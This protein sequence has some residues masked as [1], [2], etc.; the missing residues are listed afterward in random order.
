M[1]ASVARLQTPSEHEPSLSAGSHLTRADTAH[2]LGDVAQPQPGDSVAVIGAGISGLV[3]AHVLSRSYAVTV[4]EAADYAGGHTNTIEV[5]EQ[6]R[7]FGVD[8]GFIVYNETNY[9]A[10]TRLLAEL[11]VAT[12]HTSMSF[13]FHCERSGLEW[14]GS[15]LNTLMAR[16]RNALSPRFY[17]MLLDVFRFHEL[18]REGAI[19]TTGRQTV[20]EFIS[21]HGFSESFYE[22]Y[23]LPIG[24]SL[25][26][27]PAER[28]GAFP[29]KFVADFLRNHGMLQFRNRPRWRVI[30]GG[31]RRYVEALLSRLEAK[32]HLNAPID[33]V[34]RTGEGV[35][36]WAHGQPLEFDHAVVACHS[37]QALQMLADASE[38]ERQVLGPLKF[39]KNIAAL[40]TDT[41][42]LP[43]RQRAWGAWNYKLQPDESR[44]VPVTYN[45]NILQSLQAEQTYCVTLNGGD[46][47]D[48]SRLIREIVYHHPEY[49]V[50]AEPARARHHDVIGHR[51]TSYCGAYWG[52]GFHEAGVQSALRVASLFRCSL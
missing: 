21:D 49:S 27:S 7:T 10:F 36:V 22:L 29:I 4:F 41:R 45:M 26:S 40:H 44:P 15:D 33:R 34:E 2:P 11:G 48:R 16:R 42:M 28:F 20:R 25:W 5:H 37:D 46:A 50:E 32:V 12:K 13:G 23:L 47:I 35:R 14:N 9:P 1:Q 39:Q 19:D 43:T 24:A 17:A 38:T 52:N 18:D 6:G 3:A 51:R 30:E 8:T 31:S